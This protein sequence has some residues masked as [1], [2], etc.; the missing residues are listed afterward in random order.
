MPSQAANACRRRTSAS[1]HYWHFNCTNPA[2]TTYPSSLVRENTNQ[3]HTA[4][5]KFYVQSG[6]LRMVITANNSRGAALW[7]VHRALSGV[8]SF[9]AEE[10]ENPTTSDS[11]HFKLGESIRV[12]QR[13]FDREDCRT[14][15]TLSVVTEWTQLIV[16]L[17]RLEREFEEQAL[18]AVA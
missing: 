17:S 16:A 8:L 3:E 4:V 2:S 13:G 7:S 1:N 14:Y 15:E 10:S 5:A 12:N 18:E 9:I 6:N 11:Q